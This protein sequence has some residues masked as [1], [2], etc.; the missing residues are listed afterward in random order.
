MLQTKAE[1]I[2]FCICLIPAF[3]TLRW[4]FHGSDVNLGIEVFVYW[5]FLSLLATWIILA[6]YEWLTGDTISKDSNL[7]NRISLIQKK[8]PKRKIYNRSANDS[9]SPWIVMIMFGPA[10]G[11]LLLAFFSNPLHALLLGCGLAYIIGLIIV[12]KGK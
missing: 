9:R 2:L 7:E 6:I 12:N 1:K 11:G 8:L 10:A 3:F 4:L 5:G